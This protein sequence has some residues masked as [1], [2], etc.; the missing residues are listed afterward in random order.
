MHLWKLINGW[1]LETKL[2]SEIKCKYGI[3]DKSWQST[4]GRSQAKEETLCRC[5][6]VSPS[7][8]M[9]HS[10][11]VI[12]SPSKAHRIVCSCLTNL[13]SQKPKFTSNPLKVKKCHE[14]CLF[15]L[16]GNICQKIQKINFSLFLYQNPI[17]FS[18]I[19]SHLLTYCRLEPTNS[20]MTSM[21]CPA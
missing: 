15:D 20:I 3:S 12:S 2:Q 14:K 21:I 19:K 5:N 13:L 16:F 9:I 11:Y 1:Q 4:G 8:L 17:M 18:T 6:A 10:S 7:G